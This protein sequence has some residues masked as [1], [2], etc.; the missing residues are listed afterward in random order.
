MIRREVI[1]LLLAGSVHLSASL[2]LVLAKRVL[3]A[4]KRCISS[5]VAPAFGSG[6]ASVLGLS[7]LRTVRLPGSASRLA[8]AKV[9]VAL[10]WG[11]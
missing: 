4:W 7:H 6:L 9:T 10:V 1:S 11:N 5:L 3:L 8:L 2:R